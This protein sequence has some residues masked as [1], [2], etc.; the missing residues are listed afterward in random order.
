VGAPLVALAA[1]AVAYLI[2]ARLVATIGREV[3]FSV[4]SEIEPVIVVLLFGIVTDYSIFFLSGVRRRLA[5]GS[6]PRV[7]AVEGTAP[8]LPII[9]TAGLTVA[10]AAASLLVARLGFFQAFGPG[11]AL[12][13]LIG[14]LVAITLVPALLA[15]GGAGVFW[16]RR[17]DAGSGAAKGPERRALPGRNRA[18]RLATG[19][20]LA[21]VAGCAVLLLGAALGLTQ[22]EL[23]NPLIR[24]LPADSPPREAYRE[25]SR[26]F[27]PGILAPTVLVVEGEGVAERRRALAR[28]QELVESRPPVA[29]VVG[30]GDAPRERIFGAV[31][32]NTGDAARYFVVFDADPLGA[33][34]IRSLRRLRRAMPGLLEEAGLERATVAIAGDTALSEETIDEAVG[35][36]WRVAPAAL[37]TVFLILAIFLRAVVAPLYLIAASLLAVLAS[38]GLTALLFQVL[39]GH[40]DVTYFVPFAAA[41]LLLSLGSDYNVFLTGRIWQEARER[42]LREA[43]RIAGARAATPIAIAGVVLAGSFAL[44]LLVPIRAFHELAFAMSAGLVIDAFLVRTLLVPALITLV[45]GAS[46]WPGGRLDLPARPTAPAP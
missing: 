35:D 25:A 3:G 39:L 7:A 32:P 13:L 43:V 42:P 24:G 6:E 16:P 45:G 41:V 18:V 38:L 20:P 34:A 2:S 11:M 23:G 8:L 19:R 10:A 29:E 22:L 1:V 28:L 46:G 30:P 40:Q 27:A 21:T 31:L 36:A 17:P 12:S 33:R 44:L 9:F 26:G 4:P 5:A 15:I 14:L 37:L